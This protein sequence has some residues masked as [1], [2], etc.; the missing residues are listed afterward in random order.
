MKKKRLE[1]S[2]IVE[3]L[4]L[5]LIMIP[6]VII[7]TTLFPILWLVSLMSGKY[8]RFNAKF[9]DNIYLSVLHND[10][11][12]MLQERSIDYACTRSQIEWLKARDLWTMK[13]PL[14]EEVIPCMDE[15]DVVEVIN[16]SRGKKLRNNGAFLK[17]TLDCPEVY[18][19]QWIDAASLNQLFQIAEREGKMEAFC[20]IAQKANYL[21]HG[22]NSSTMCAVLPHCGW[23]TKFD[24]LCR[25][26]K[27]VLIMIAS[28]GY[29]KRDML[30]LLKESPDNG[31]IKA[32]L[33]AF[34]VEEKA[35][36]F[37]KFI[38]EKHGISQKLLKKLPEELRKKVD[39]LLNKQ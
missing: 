30:Y 16:D 33:E 6:A 17:R 37:V 29:L 39:Q 9:H 8:T 25:F 5:V 20:L 24:I 28:T 21:T 38:A 3:V 2:E 32:L 18:S 36:E 10:I 12:E 31:K 23:S 27:E 22:L 14:W 15:N 13:S 19:G 1:I 26:D 11:V 35:G 34:D 4:L 7:N